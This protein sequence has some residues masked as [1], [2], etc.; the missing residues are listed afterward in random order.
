MPTTR[1]PPSEPNLRGPAS[2]DEALF[3]RDLMEKW[4]NQRYRLQFRFGEDSDGE[5]A[6]WITLFV[7]PDVNP[8][9]ETINEIDQL[10]ESIRN[11]VINSD[12]RRWPYIQVKTE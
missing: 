1:I 7:Q 8:S 3:F 2:G 6:V 11:E 10:S 9:R 5:P 4:S 12:F